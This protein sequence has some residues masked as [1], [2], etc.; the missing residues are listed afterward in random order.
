[1]TLILLPGTS[2]SPAVDQ[3]AITA[4]G[5]KWTT[6]CRNYAKFRASHLSR[7]LRHSNVRCWVGSCPLPIC[8]RRSAQANVR[9][10]REKNNDESCVKHA[11]CSELFFVSADYLLHSA[12]SEP[13]TEQASN[14]HHQYDL[15]CRIRRPCSHNEGKGNEGHAIRRRDDEYVARARHSELH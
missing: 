11:C 13:S 1:M 15:I 3:N 5:R 10:P 2:V 8:L 4:I 9:S 6:R 14:G 7:L 12:S